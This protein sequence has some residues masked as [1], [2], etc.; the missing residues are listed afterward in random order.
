MSN[1]E[2]PAALYTRYT[3]GFL[4]SLIF[5]AI[6]FVTV[7]NGLVHGSLLYAILALCAIMQLIIQLVFFLHLGRGKDGRWNIFSFGSMT[8]IVV[9]VVFGSLWIMNNLHY[10]MMPGSE[11]DKYIQD[12]EA[13][14]RTESY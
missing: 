13:I 14:E 4:L 10:N 12:E 11:V 7:V 9:I 3:T 2:R 5:T 1:H 6:P 8:I